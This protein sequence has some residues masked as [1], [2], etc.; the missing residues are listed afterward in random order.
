MLILPSP[1]RPQ[2]L[3]SQ[4]HS[5][6]PLDGMLGIAA[7]QGSGATS[8][9]QWMAQ[10]MSPASLLVFIGYSLPAYDTDTLAMIDFALQIAGS[11]QEIHVVGWE[12]DFRSQEESPTCRRYAEVLRRPFQ[13][14]PGGVEDWVRNHVPD[15][16][17]IPAALRYE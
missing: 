6:A 16:L 2:H 8:V 1:R 10:A 13:F 11:L 17:H 3:L 7:Q 5:R 9:L 14:F 15:R 12:P 4:T